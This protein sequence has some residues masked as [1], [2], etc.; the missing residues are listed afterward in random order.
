M[1]ITEVAAREHENGRWIGIGSVGGDEHD[2]IGGK[3]RCCQRQDFQ[4]LSSCRRVDCGAH[5]WVSLGARHDNRLVH[6]VEE[7]TAQHVDIH[8]AGDAAGIVIIAPGEDERADEAKFL[9][10]NHGEA[11]RARGTLLGLAEELGRLK[12]RGDAGGI[13]A[14]AQTST[15][16]V[17]DMGAQHH[18]F[19]AQDGIAAGQHADQIRAQREGLVVTLLGTPGNKPVSSETFDDILAR[20]VRPIR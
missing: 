17:V 11:D 2:V 12:Q 6:D 5:A 10:I 7:G 16:D 14:R 18:I 8:D 9:R 13:V 3:K 20:D 1:I 15:T 19:I 4:I